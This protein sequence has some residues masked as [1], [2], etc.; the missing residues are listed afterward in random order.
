[1]PV[2]TV[3]GRRA[4]VA[5]GRKLVLAIED[6]G[7]DIGHRCGGK[8]RCTTCRVAVED[9][10]PTTFTRAEYHKLRDAEL[11]GEVRLACQLLVEDDLSVRVLRTKQSE[12]WS[13]TGPAVAEELTPDGGRWTRE[14]L[15][16]EP[17]PA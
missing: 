7:I 8:A 14:H 6:L 11:L 10:E 16:A 9:G 2:I 13:D 1:M 17:R 3:D 5:S 4:E 15:E 12:G